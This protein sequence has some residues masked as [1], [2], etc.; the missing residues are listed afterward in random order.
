MGNVKQFA[1]PQQKVRIRRLAEALIAHGERLV[2]EQTRRRKGLQNAGEQRPVQIIGNDHAI[3]LQARQR[4]QPVFQVRL[5]D[6]DARNAGECRKRLGVAVDGA[7]PESQR[8]QKTTMTTAAA[9]EI[10]NLATRYNRARPASDPLR[11]L[12]EAAGL[13]L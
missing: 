13:I 4:P 9:S 7:N 2:D 6:Y 11:R 10:Q 5:L 12:S 8:S 3:E 1:R